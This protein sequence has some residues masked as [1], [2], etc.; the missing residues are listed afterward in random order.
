MNDK[1]N[2][3][4]AYYNM[5]ELGVSPLDIYVFSQIMNSDEGFGMDDR[6]ILDKTKEIR[7]SIDRDY[8]SRLTV[9]EHIQRI[10]EGDCYY[11]EEEELM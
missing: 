1:D 10:M 6:D 7:D 9:D 3:L 11:D 5:I 4:K 8:N 2:I